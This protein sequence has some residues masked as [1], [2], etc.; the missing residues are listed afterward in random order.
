VWVVIVQEKW[1]PCQKGIAHPRVADGRDGFHVRRVAANILNKQART[2][3]KGWSPSFGIRRG[4]KTPNVN[5]LIFYEAGRR[6]SGQE[7]FFGTTQAP[8]NG[9]EIWH[10]EC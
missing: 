4:E 9:Y 1:V 10:L 7:G 5:L 6:V 2:A 8:K 3:E